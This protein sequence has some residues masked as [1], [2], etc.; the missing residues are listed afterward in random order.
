MQVAPVFCKF[1]LRH[2][3]FFQRPVSVPAFTTQKE[4]R[5]GFLLLL[6]KAKSKDYVQ[7]WFCSWLCRE[8]V[9]TE[10]LTGSGATQRPPPTPRTTLSISAFSPRALNRVCGQLGFIWMCS[11]TSITEMHLKVSEKSKNGNFGGGG[12]LEMLKF[13]SYASLLYAISAN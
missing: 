8:A 7:C 12:G 9:H 3:V 2:F 4:T 13:F 10:H 11:V 6:E 1:V 5:R